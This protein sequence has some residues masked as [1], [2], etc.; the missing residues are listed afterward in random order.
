MFKQKGFT[1]VELLIVIIVV[2]ILAALAIVSYN[3]IRDR[4]VNSQLLSSFDAVEK[5][6]RLYHAD[7]GE[8]PSIMDNNGSLIGTVDNPDMPYACVG[9]PSDYP[10]TNLF[11][12]DECYKSESTNYGINTP[13]FN[14]QIEP[15]ASNLHVSTNNLIDEGGMGVRGILYAGHRSGGVLFYMQR[16]DRECGRGTK[17][18]MELSE[19]STENATVCGIT[20]GE[21]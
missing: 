5:V 11:E 8:Y 12:K 14:N 7:K 4:A 13:V 15:F 19:Q 6:I 16:G 9:Q 20:F 1:I 3:G 17:D 2:A 18:I 10:K 21:F